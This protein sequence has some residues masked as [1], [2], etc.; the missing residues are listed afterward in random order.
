MQ[1]RTSESRTTRSDRCW[2]EPVL[3]QYNRSGGNTSDIASGVLRRAR[4]PVPGHRL[5]V[6]PVVGGGAGQDCKM[7]RR[8]TE[9][10]AERYRSQQ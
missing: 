1:G 10:A 7:K 6:V 9:A 4:Y 3:G 5:A 2:L 8:S